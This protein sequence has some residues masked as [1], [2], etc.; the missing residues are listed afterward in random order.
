MQVTRGVHIQTLGQLQPSFN[1]TKENVATLWMGGLNWKQRLSAKAT[2]SARDA[3][4]E[5]NGGPC[6]GEQLAQ[7]LKD[8]D[9]DMRCSNQPDKD[10]RRG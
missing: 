1:V 6:E 4:C 10:H 8:W 3:C 2:I 7:C 5:R 9:K